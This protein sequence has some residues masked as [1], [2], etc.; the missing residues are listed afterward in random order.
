MY[1]VYI[2]LLT[3]MRKKIIKNEPWY[4]KKGGLFGPEYFSQ[5][6]DI[7]TRERTEK[8]VEFLIKTLKIKKRSKILDIPCGYGRHSV[9]FAKKGF[10]VTGQD[11]NSF[12]LAKAKQFAKK[13]KVDIR[14]V[15]A[16]MRKIPFE[17][18]FDFAFNL[19]TSFGYL[20]NDKED[21][22]MLKAINKSLRSGGLFVLDILNRERILRSYQSRDWTELKDGSLLLFGR[23]F[24]YVE[25]RTY[26]KRIRI[27]KSGKRKEI[28]LIL[29]IYT[30]T[31][32]I[33]MLKSAGFEYGSI[34]GDYEGREYN[35]DSSRCI[36]IAKKK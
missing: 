16:D 5:Y 15:K 8:E 26:E 14:W 20:E 33:K 36:I 11:L 17:N 31:E 13:E 18:E 21:A 25:G 27:S 2:L 23:E 4:S 7:L 29:R 35:S 12:F 1:H 34:Y 30:L 19:Y 28:K 24:D 22:I 3:F 32:I 9:E 6:E 10:L